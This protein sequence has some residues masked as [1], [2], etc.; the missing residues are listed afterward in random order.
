MNVSSWLCTLIWFAFCSVIVGETLKHKYN[1]VV[2]E[3]TR[4]FMA[5]GPTAIM[6]D[7]LPHGNVIVGT[8][9]LQTGL[10][11][12]SYPPINLAHNVTAVLPDCFAMAGSLGVLCVSFGN[13]E[14]LYFFS[15]ISVSQ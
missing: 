4:G 14:C 1:H 7:F 10:L 11:S 2:A 9:D 8:L 12:P 3:A 13:F 5:R 15:T 6:T